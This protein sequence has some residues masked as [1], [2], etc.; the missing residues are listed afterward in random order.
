MKRFDAELSL[1]L[2]HDRDMGMTTQNIDLDEA[3]R[4]WAIRVQDPSFTDWDAFTQWLADDPAHLAAYEAALDDAAWAADLLSSPPPGSAADETLQAI[5]DD[6]VVPLRPRRRWF[7]VGGAIAAA[8][9][10]IA[11]WSMLDRNPAMEIVTSPGEH[12]TIAL[13]DGSRVILNGGTRITIDPDRPREVILANGEALFDVKHDDSHPFV[14]LANGT[15]LLDAGTVF[16]VI[17]EGDSLDVA[18]AHGVVIYEPGR[19]DIRLQAGDA[20]SRP[21]RKAQPVLRKASPQ[22]IGGWQTGHLQYSNA[23]LGDVARD[24]GRNLGTEIRLGNGA[25]SLRFSGTL[26][27]DGPSEAVLARIAPLLGVNFAANG[28]AWTMTPANGAPAN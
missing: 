25:E 28:N 8:L 13:D 3:A 23:S 16:N 5:E 12:R 6:N 24:L 7:A 2:R 4:L 21:D 27:V 1:R 19:D 14:V 15:R 10:G 17:S 20:L 26:V 22:T 18:V 11:T 9:V